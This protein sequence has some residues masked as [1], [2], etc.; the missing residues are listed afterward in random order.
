MREFDINVANSVP[1]ERQLIKTMLGELREFI[2]RIVRDASQCD[3][4]YH[5]LSLLST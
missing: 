3:E 2:E 4:I 5:S 1:A